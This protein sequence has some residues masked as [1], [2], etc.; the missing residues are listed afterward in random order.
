LDTQDHVCVNDGHWSDP[1]IVPECLSSQLR[2][3]TFK[4]YKGSKSE[5][6]F[7]KYIM[8]T[9]KVLQNMTIHTTLDIDLKQPMLETFSLCP[10]GSA[11]CN[12]QFDIKP[13]QSLRSPKALWG[14]FMNRNLVMIV[15]LWL[16]MHLG[17]LIITVIILT[18]AAV[19]GG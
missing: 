3:F 5:V 15:W 9:S 1:Q 16:Q 4:Y 7:A 8:Q 17:L 2:T 13:A 11:T 10:R 6:E 19:V 18:H 14:L 12:L